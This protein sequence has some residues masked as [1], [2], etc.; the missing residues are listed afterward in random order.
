MSLRLRLTA[1]TAALIA[2]STSV[3]GIVIYVNAG[4][5]QTDRVDE[6]L[7][8]DIS[9]AR[10]RALA[11][12]RET[13]TGDAYVSVALGRVNR[14][15]TILRLRSAG[16]PDAPIPVPDLSAEQIVQ[17][18]IAPITVEGTPT[19]R[20]VV[21]QPVPGRATVVA[22]APLTSAQETL[23]ALATAIIVAVI[24][25]TIVGALAA[26]LLVWRAFRP[27]R[28]MVASASRI[29]GGDT[30]HRLP[31]TRTGTEIGDLTESM[32]VMIDS[33]AD[34]LAEAAASEDRLRTFVSD[35]SHE[36]RTPLTVIRG[37]SELIA[38]R[39]DELGDQDRAA[40]A[41][42]ESESKRLDRLVT[43]LLALEARRARSA[44]ARE[45]VDLGGL[46]EVSFA[47]VAV[48]DPTRDVTV[49]TVAA[50]VWV[51][52]DDLRLVL[53]N[54]TQNLV[55][56]TPSGSPAAVSVT[57]AGGLVTLMVDD[58]GPGIPAARRSSLL[59]PASTRHRS[60]STEGFGLGLRIM[61]E[62]VEANGGT[63]EL[64]DSP[65]GGLRV[66]IRIP[67]ASHH[68][69]HPAESGAGAPA[70]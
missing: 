9:Q 29:A 38:Q 69:D 31:T 3:L 23:A 55:R 37:Y 12:G 13:P 5:I 61:V 57:E 32:N 59:D 47:D 24:S 60:S 6:I 7:Y 2:L 30:D 58:S 28:A 11:E 20:V 62:A 27:M 46:T 51:A 1:L 39:S 42:I 66:T 68:A 63:M 67:S 16:T 56:H 34:A 44:D 49:A 22:A 35:A 52:P 53:G 15:G 18:S 50:E 26:W 21:Q 40:L 54:L 14:D 25:V 48:L 64:G 17:A 65:M 45:V 36:I 43:Q 10:I 19:M 8:S 4:S 70:G 41:R 33:L